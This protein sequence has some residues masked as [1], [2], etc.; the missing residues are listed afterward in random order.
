METKFEVK[1]IFNEL[2]EVQQVMKKLEENKFQILEYGEYLNYEK[3]K[4]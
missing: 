4:Q 2:K 3:W 1:L